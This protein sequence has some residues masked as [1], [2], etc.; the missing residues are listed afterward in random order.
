[1]IDTGRFGAVGP[2]ALRKWRDEIGWTRALVVARVVLG[3]ML[4]EA[5]VRAGW[6]LRAGYFGDAFHWPVL[7]EALVASK[8]VYTALVAA[9]AV[10]A[11]MVIAGLRPRLALFGSALA[12]AYGLLCDRLQFHN[13]RA[14][15]AGYAL[16]L[17]LAPCDRTR[18]GPLWAARLA[19]LQVATIYLASGGSKLLDPDWRGG[20]VIL[21]RFVL[22]R[23]QAEAAGVPGA[24]I[25]AFSRPGV[26][27][28]L[29]A[30][31][32]ATE[33]LLCVGL[34][35]R[36]TRAFALWWGTAFHLTIE[37]TSRV[38]G[39]TWI[40][41]GMY[42]LFS[43]PDLHAR[44]LLYDANDARGRA[45][46]RAV[47]SLDWLGRFEVRARPPGDA[48]H[49]VAVVERDGREVRGLPAAAALARATPLLFPL[50]VPLAVLA[51]VAGVQYGRRRIP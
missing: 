3:L 35:P 22:F 29:A 26:A 41:L 8:P 42:A 12:L 14:A 39:F 17:S 30:A 33:L 1:M 5:A 50:W 48:E 2:S 10:M 37:A 7:P 4:L 51:R 45:I 20:D 27:A 31:A 46:A 9:E 11:M 15:M 28:A 49:A 44:R 21:T 6:E 43:I 24:I 38:E 34:W 25:D 40:T 32:I 47:R 23:A 36:R 18:Q 16:L 13:N 19:Q